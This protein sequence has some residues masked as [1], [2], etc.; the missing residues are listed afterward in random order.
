MPNK[1]TSI[2]NRER[3]KESQKHNQDTGI[4]NSK[5]IRRYESIFAQKQKT[6]CNEGETNNK[7]KI[8]K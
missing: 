5:K 4:Y 7:D 2:G 3:K 6:Q 8:N 1:D